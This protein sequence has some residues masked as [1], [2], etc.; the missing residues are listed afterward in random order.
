MPRRPFPSTATPVAAGTVAAPSEDNVLRFDDA[1]EFSFRGD[2]EDSMEDMDQQ[3][4]EAQKRLAALR[5]QQ[6][7][8][9][10]Q[11]QILENLRMKQERFVTGK[12]EMADKLERALSTIANELEDARRRVEDLALTQRD[13][14]DR[15]DDLKTFL[16]ERW[17]RSQIDQELDRALAS[18]G[19]AEVTYEKGLH[20]LGAHRPST[21]AADLPAISPIHAA[22]AP[23]QPLEDVSAEPSPAAAPA[24]ARALALGAREDWVTWARRG[25]AFNAALITALVLLLIIARMIF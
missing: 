18:L 14:E 4:R 21:A 24:S 15:L 8:V 22:L 9:E 7:E 3:V 20:R 25:L 23:H 6:E 17:Q 13:F 2:E 1:P 11:K 5:A 19:D 10:R 16:P 12:K